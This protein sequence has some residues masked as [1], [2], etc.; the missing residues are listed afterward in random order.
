MLFKTV[1]RIID[2]NE[3]RRVSVRDLGC[4]Y[5]SPEL[6]VLEVSVKNPLM[7]GSKHDTINWW[8]GQRL[9]YQSD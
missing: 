3:W 9:H 7:H 6:A 1:D 2:G 4:D 8:S 5:N